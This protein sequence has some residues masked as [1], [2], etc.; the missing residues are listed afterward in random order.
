MMNKIGIEY[1][2]GIVPV[3]LYFPNLKWLGTVWRGTINFNEKEPL[4]W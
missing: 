3:F 1:G 4:S 2:M